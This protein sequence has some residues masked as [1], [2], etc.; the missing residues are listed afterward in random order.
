MRPSRL[1]L[2]LAVMLL[3]AATIHAQTASTG[4]IVGTIVGTTSDVLPGVIVEILANG[5]SQTTVTD[6]KGR[7]AFEKMG[8]GTYVLTASLP[9]FRNQ[10][11]EG[12]AVAPDTTVTVDLTLKLACAEVSDFIV[13][14]SLN[15]L[16][17]SDLVA[18]V[19]VTEHGLDRTIEF[20]DSCYTG[21]EA[22]ATIVDVVH[23]SRARW[24]RGASIPLQAVNRTLHTGQEYLAFMDFDES[25]QRFVLDSIRFA[26]VTN[27]QVEWNADLDLG[28]RDGA[29]IG[30]ALERLRETYQRYSRYR[31]Y[32]STEPTRSLKE[33]RYKTAWVP[34]GSMTLRGN[35]WKDERPFEFVDERSDDR[36]LPRRGD[37]IRVTKESHAQIL[38]FGARAEEL[39]DVSPTTRGHERN[40]SDLTG[41][42]VS[43]G[44]VYTVADIQYEQLEDERIVW[45]RL[46]A[47]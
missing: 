31:Q 23:A 10:Q 26:P 16:L 41:A 35:E 13:D 4:R 11:R 43:P 32:D 24:R 3:T 20:T 1:H 29:T 22:S 5:E 44:I 19:R 7:Y 30:T 8:S 25:Q 47:D 33:L 18:H 12:I 15:Q 14:T 6:E 28:F 36:P 2:A 21:N 42:R 38:D 17:A 34:L 40:V 9:G 27:G 45:V 46:V 37:R 39:R